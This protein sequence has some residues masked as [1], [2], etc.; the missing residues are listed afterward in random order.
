MLLQ[1]GVDGFAGANKCATMVRA[2][3][4]ST[5]APSSKSTDSGRR[6]THELHVSRP[7]IL[8]GEVPDEQCVRVQLDSML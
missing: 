4:G 8:T 1:S 7:S 3:P 5:C 2:V 6:G